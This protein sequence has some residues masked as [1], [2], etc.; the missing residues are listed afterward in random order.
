VTDFPAT[1]VLARSFGSALVIQALLSSSNFI[2]SSILIRRASDVQYGY[3]VLVFNSLLLLTALQGA[4][5]QAPLVLRL[6]RLD[7]SARAGLIG[8]LLREQRAVV[9]V[10]L[11]GAGL[12]V[13]A[14]WLTR[15]LE[16]QAAVL[17][18]FATLA[19]AATLERELLR[20]VLFA[21]RRANEVLKG[22]LCH[23]ALLVTGVG[24]TASYPASGLLAVVALAGASHASALLLARRLRQSDEWSSCGPRGL[25][26]SFVPLGAWSVAGAAAHWALS[27][28][29]SYIVA[30][31]LGVQSVAALAATRLPLMP[32]N[33]LSAGIG[34]QLFPLTADWV[35]RLG[36]TPAARRLALVSIGLVAFGLCYF[37]LLWMFRDWV[38]TTLLHRRFAQRDPL[39]LLWC[40]AFMLML[41]R[42]QLVKLLAAR[43]RFPPLASITAASALASLAFS[44]GAMVWL[45]ELGA[46]AGIVFGEL[47]NV[48]GVVALTFLE[49]RRA[50]PAPV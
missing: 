20:M 18:I 31:T 35:Y 45:G 15:V 36:V 21:Y 12:I 27:Q 29:Y 9:R 4:F 8:A 37:A 3:Y 38:F 14:L 16:R 33:L 23:V 41:V 6:I 42:D 5:I 44:Y 13:V 46:V 39:L 24:L 50:V 17:A 34:T 48:I 22:D 32:L 11:Y 43:E 28:G 26:R 2:S 1:R 7:T 19:A 47:V 25:L 10:L 49:V 30:A 40:A